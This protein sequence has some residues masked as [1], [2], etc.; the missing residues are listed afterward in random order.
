[1]MR[2]QDRINAL[3]GIVDTRWDSRRSRLVV[4]Y[5][6]A[7][8]KDTVKIRVAGAIREANLQRAIDEITLISLSQ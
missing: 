2:I 1:M 6:D 5:S 8:P 4:Y 3:D 7:I